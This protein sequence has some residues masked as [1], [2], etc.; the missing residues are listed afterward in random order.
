MIREWNKYNAV[1]LSGILIDVMCYRFLSDYNYKDKSFFYYDWFTRDF[2]DYLI[3]HHDQLYWIV[4]GSK[5]HVSKDYSFL[6]KAKEALENSKIAIE[7]EKQGKEYTSIECW[8]E[9]YGPKFKH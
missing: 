1:G 6:R 9:I 4:P 5:W 8:R 2:M 7:A 3:K